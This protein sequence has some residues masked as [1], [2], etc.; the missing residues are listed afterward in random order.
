MLTWRLG[1]SGLPENQAALVPNHTAESQ[2][3]PVSWEQAQNIPV[4]AMGRGATPQ[5]GLMQDPL[6]LIV[7]DGTTVSWSYWCDD[8]IRRFLSDAEAGAARQRGVDRRREV[9]RAKAKERRARAK[10]R[11]LKSAQ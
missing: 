6:A 1:F 10:E 9:V 3:S 4:A 2:A 7:S 11:R 5:F 8:G